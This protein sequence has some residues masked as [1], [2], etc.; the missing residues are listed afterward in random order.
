MAY[1]SEKLSGSKLNYST[2]DVEFIVVVQVA[3][4]WKHYLFHK[5]FILYTG[6]EALKHLHK[7]DKV[8]FRHASWVAYC[9]NLLPL[10]GPT[11]E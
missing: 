3:K 5:E 4:H 6:H 11:D 9:D 8:S 1:F 2:Y 10:T 7:Q